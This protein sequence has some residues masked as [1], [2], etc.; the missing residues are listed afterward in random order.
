MIHPKR[1][2]RCAKYIGLSGLNWLF[3]RPEPRP[4]RRF[5]WPGWV[6]RAGWL[7]KSLPK[8]EPLNGTNDSSVSLYRVVKHRLPMS[9]A[10]I[11]Q[12]LVNIQSFWTKKFA[13]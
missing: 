7:G 1:E 10:R 11:A 5:C 4:K 12:R 9:Y 13:K 6:A 8:S 3:N 2:G